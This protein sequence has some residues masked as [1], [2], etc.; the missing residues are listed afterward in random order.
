L[1]P[2]SPWKAILLMGLYACV[3]QNM[4]TEIGG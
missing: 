1:A 2:S 4:A 3:A